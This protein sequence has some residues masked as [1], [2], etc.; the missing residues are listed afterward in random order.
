MS[1]SDW[2]SVSTKSK[3]IEDY[4]RDE[5]NY[6]IF[7]NETS[8]FTDTE[9]R[10]WIDINNTLYSPLF[11]MM[12]GDF[13]NGGNEV[14]LV[15]NRQLL[16]C[17]GGPSTIEAADT[18]I[19]RAQ[20]IHDIEGA[21]FAADAFSPFSDVPK[22]RIIFLLTFYLSNYIVRPWRIVD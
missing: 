13:Y 2:R 10:W 19:K 15:K 11:K 18:V 12:F 5:D 17:A 9:W 6:T 22:I 4:W 7:E 21:V 8:L 14:A 16:C 3:T 20:K 1:Y